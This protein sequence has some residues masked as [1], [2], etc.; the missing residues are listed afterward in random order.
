MEIPTLSKA[1]RKHRGFLSHNNI[2]NALFCSITKTHISQTSYASSL[3][4]PHK[5]RLKNQVFT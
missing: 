3:T 1:G 4:Q 2:T 5:T